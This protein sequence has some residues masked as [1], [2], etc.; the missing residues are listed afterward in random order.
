MIPRALL[1]RLRADS[2][3][4]D[5]GNAVLEFVVLGTLFM[6]PLIYVI[7]AVFRVQGTAYGVTEA[8]REAGRAFVVADSSDEAYARA[9]AAATL[10][11]RNQGSAAF[12][13]ITGLKVSCISGSCQPA[14]TP[15]AEIRV[16]ID[17]S[18]SLPMLPASIFGQPTTIELRATHDETVDK[19]RGAR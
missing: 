14:L 8:A 6:V 18:V 11:L 17:V 16:E 4:G 2:D 15:G 3:A 19:Y 13:C 1:A 10:A 9:C 5:A 7:L 12:D